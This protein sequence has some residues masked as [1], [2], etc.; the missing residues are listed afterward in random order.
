MVGGGDTKILCLLTELPICCGKQ[1]HGKINSIE[2]S[3][4]YNE[5]YILGHGYVC[6]VGA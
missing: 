3:Q 5:V 6:G 1:K 2:S 4:S